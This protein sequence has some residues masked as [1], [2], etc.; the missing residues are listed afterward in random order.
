MKK[1]VIYWAIISFLIP[2]LL[3]SVSAMNEAPVSDDSSSEK[4]CLVVLLDG[5]EFIGTILSQSQD[6]INLITNN[7]EYLSFNIKQISIIVNLLDF[8]PSSNYNYQSY[9]ISFLDSSFK[10]KSKLL[11]VHLNDK[12]ILYGFLISKSNNNTKIISPSNYLQVIP[13][14]II[15]TTIS[16][17][18]DS[19]R[20]F[21]DSSSNDFHKI[22][23]KDGNEITGRIISF[24]NNIYKF[25]TTSDIIID[26]PAEK[27]S[28]IKKLAGQVVVANSEG[29]TRTGHDYFLHRLADLSMPEKD[30]SQWLKSFFQ[31]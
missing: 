5:T 19:T 16:E 10:N 8:I 24:K 22:I 20:K 29:L 9:K 6:S 23:L 13:N 12:E 18:S 27:V 31:W 17:F 28:E 21:S 4:K 3:I 7:N 14:D 26:I 2:M 1:N 11:K 25:K 15:D 30:I